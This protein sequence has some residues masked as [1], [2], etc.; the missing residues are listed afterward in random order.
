MQIRFGIAVDGGE[1]H[2]AVGF[3]QFR[4]G[5]NDGCRIGNVFHHF[6]TRYHI[7]AVRLLGGEVF[8]A[9]AA[10]IDIS[11]VLSGRMGSSGLQGFFRH[12]DA[13]N[14]FCAAFG[15]ALRQ[16]TAAAAYIQHAFACQ[17]GIAVDIVEAQGVDVMQGLE[18]AVF[19]PPFVGDLAELGDFAGIYV[20]VL[21]AHGLLL[22]K[23]IRLILADCASK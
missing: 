20:V 10:V 13:D 15:H 4:T 3:D 19:I 8:D 11:N 2:H 14:V 23:I 6:H 5:L 17:S 18:F 21:I 16:N 22:H 12:I 7:E 9:D 1:K